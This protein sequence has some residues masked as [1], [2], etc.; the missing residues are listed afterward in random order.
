M[1]SRRTDFPSVEIAGEQ[2]KNK[3]RESTIRFS[4]LLERMNPNTVGDHHSSGKIRQ[5]SHFIK[6]FHAQNVIN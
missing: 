4:D 3:S 6:P 1:G 5:L 2:E